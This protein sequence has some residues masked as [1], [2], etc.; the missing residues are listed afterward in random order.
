V[1]RVTI[2]TVAMLAGMFLAAIDTTAVS[3]A[4]PEIVEALGGLQLYAWVFSI[5]MLTSTATMPLFG[6]LSDLYG[7]KT[8]YLTGIGLF[9][10][11]S[12]LCSSA[13]S[14]PQLILYRGLQGLG[15]GALLP[16]T[17][18]IIGDLF[19]LEQRARMQGIFSAVWGLSSIIGPLIGGTLVDAWSWRAIFYLNVPFGIVAAM[20]VALYLEGGAEREAPVRL[21]LAPLGALTAG[22]TILIWGLQAI[23]SGRPWLSWA[24][25]GSTLAGIGLLVTFLRLD[26]RSPAPIFPRALL[27]NRVFTVS[28]WSGFFAGAALFGLVAYLPLYVQAVRGGNA[29]AAGGSLTPISLGWFISSIAAGRLL[30]RFGYRRVTLPGLAI[31]TVGLVGLVNLTATT[32]I[33]WL[34]GL[35]VICGV[36]FG[37]SMTA[38]L[39][40]VQSSVSPRMLGTATAAVPFTRNIGGAIGVGVMGVLVLRRVGDADLPALVASGQVDPLLAGIDVAMGVG[41]CFAL[42]ALLAAFAMP[43]GRAQD[44]VHKDRRAPDSE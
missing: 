26:R 27:S 4:M 36:G 39:I 10:G 6:Y 43:A 12:I 19:D 35:L 33:P 44:F 3:T 18:T 21:D 8:L 13:I 22:T 34:A 30:L 29:T 25:A 42:A 14:M 38:M 31:L 24:V 41:A 32:P 1:S 5:Y 40:A 20:L 17:M 16:L 23:G 15:A 2:I 7:R 37:L 9:V 11:G 28:A